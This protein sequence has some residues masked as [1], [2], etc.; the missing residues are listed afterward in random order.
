[1]SLKSWIDQEIILCKL[2]LGKCGQN[3][4]RFEDF[5]NLFSL[6]S[7]KMDDKVILEHVQ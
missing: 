1:M 5:T 6:H 2:P 4:K 7:F 3:N